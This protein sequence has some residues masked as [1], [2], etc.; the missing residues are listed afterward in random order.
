MSE[1]IP[2]I[3][4]S[5]VSSGIVSSADSFQQNDLD[6]LFIFTVYGP[7]PNSCNFFNLPNSI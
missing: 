2:S 5:K 4:Y 7:D 6:M 3:L 1:L